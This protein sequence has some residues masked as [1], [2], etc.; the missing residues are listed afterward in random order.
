MDNSIASC[1][2]CSSEATTKEHII[3]QWLQKHFNLKNQKLGLWNN[4]AILYHQAVIKLCQKCNG[5]SLGQLEKRIEN[6]TASEN[7]YYLWALKIRF[8]LSVKDSTLPIDVRDKSKGPLVTKDQGY[9]GQEFVQE[10]IRS[11]SIPDFIFKPNPFGSVFLLDNPIL[12]GKFGF[13]D[14]P[15]PYWAI[16]ISLPNH[17]ILAVLLTD[18]G[19]VKKEA[20]KH[21]KT[22]GGIKNITTHLHATSTSQLLHTLMLKLL[23]N[24]YQITNI[25]RQVSSNEKSIY[26]PALPAQANYRKKHTKEAYIHLAQTLN[27]SAEIGIQVFNKLSKAMQA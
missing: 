1:P 24:Q 13:V 8:L 6:G 23:V 19:M 14:A 17:K 26:G 9:Y 3:P 16:T 11:V 10:A 20:I 22:K 2:L 21:Y 25:P 12:D 5:N 27:L 15:F 7:D 18:K 4:T